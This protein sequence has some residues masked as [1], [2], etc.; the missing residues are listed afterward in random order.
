MFHAMILPI[1]GLLDQIYYHCNRLQF[2][3]RLSEN[4][5]R[6]RITHYKGY[7]LQLEDGVQ[8]KKGDLLVKIHLHNHL[9]V[10]KMEHLQSDVRRALFVHDLVKESMP[11]LAHFMKSHPLQEQIKGVIGVTVLNRG[12][13]RLGF[14]CF[15]LKNPIYRHWKMLYMAPMTAFCQGDLSY[16]WSKKMEPKYLV[17]SKNVLLNRYDTG[18]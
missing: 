10:R 7:P 16:L 13:K 9:L 1:W 4:I 5:F 18:E 17:M 3:D 15:D 12:V 14:H 2:V 8:I 6:V 11:G